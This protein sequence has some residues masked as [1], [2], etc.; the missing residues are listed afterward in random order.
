MKSK[1]NELVE[2]KILT[3][4]YEIR[5]DIYGDYSFSEF[6]ERSSGKIVMCLI[7]IRTDNLHDLDIAGIRSGYD[8]D[9]FFFLYWP[10]SF[11]K[12]GLSKPLNAVFTNFDSYI[13]RD[14][15]VLSL[16]NLKTEDLKTLFGED[17]LFVGKHCNMVGISSFY[18]SSID[19]LTKKMIETPVSPKV[20]L[21]TVFMNNE[22]NDMDKIETESDLINS[23]CHIGEFITSFCSDNIV[24]GLCY[25]LISKIE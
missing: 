19:D 3:N 22:K 6:H 23:F 1:I 16:S 7:S 11:M 14:S 8:E 25:T 17:G 13:T 2:N 5:E 18:D 21:L 24:E 20:N 10:N 15:L 12:T 9:I 4:L